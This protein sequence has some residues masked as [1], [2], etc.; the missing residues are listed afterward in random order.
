MKYLVRDF[1]L[2]ALL[3]LI[4]I[5]GRL[6]LLVGFGWE[7][8]PLITWDWAVLSFRFDL[9]TCTHLILPTLALSF[10]AIFFGE[11]KIIARLKRL[12]ASFILAL[13]MFFAILNVVFF[14]EYKSQFNQ[15]I[16]GIFYDDF[17]AIMMTIIKTYPIFLIVL[18]IFAIVVASVACTKFV[19]KS[20][21]N[22]ENFKSLRAKVA[23][24]AACIFLVAFFMRGAKI[25]GKEPSPRDAVISESAFLNN[26]IPTSAYCIRHE[27][28]TH[29]EFLSFSDSL[30]FFD[31]SADQIADI[32]KKTFKRDVSSIDEGLTRKA[33]GSPL[34]E[35]P[36]HIFLIIAESHS[37]WPLYEK[38]KS[39][40]LMPETRKLLKNSLGSS[41]ALSAG[42]CTV[43]SV[44]SILGGIPFAMLSASC[45]DDYPSDFSIA[46]ICKDMGYK[47]NFFCASS[48]EWCNIGVFTKKIGFDEN[49]GG[50]VMN[51]EFYLHEWGVPDRQ[52]YNYLLARNYDTP[53]LNVILTVSNHPPYDVNLKAEGCPNQID[54]P[55]ENKVQHTWYAD[56]RLGDFIKKMRKKY[57]NSLFIVTGDHCA[58]LNPEYLGEDFENRMC[59]PIIFSGK[60]IEDASLAR[61]VGPS[62]HMDIIPTLTEMIAPKG[63][64]YKAW[65]SN[66]MERERFIEPINPYAI[67]YGGKLLNPK[68]STCPDEARRK[69]NNFMALAYWRAV[70]GSQFP[71]KK[72]NQ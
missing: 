72:E 56:N 35:K 67:Y 40:N 62:S 15:W 22:L 59:V 52:F 44:T 3:M 45:I 30:E 57:P 16:L 55:L 34:K 37:A 17:T 4:Y 51:E 26:L 49:F 48:I 65:G 32:A 66:L 5:L 25:E 19:F 24:F 1:I 42:I 47:C 53:S 21:A 61:Q 28:K 33:K 69:M 14:S 58:R 6:A 10:I 27:L 36:E 23:A 29:F 68:T 63:Y 43:D 70:K 20:T 13:S 41:H 2:F 31:A 39:R 60:P 9:M 50:N 12:Y 11:R 7:K 46:K 54:N 8:L 64:E 71:D 38:Y 18:G